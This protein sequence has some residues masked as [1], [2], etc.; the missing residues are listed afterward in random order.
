MDEKKNSIRLITVGWMI[1]AFVI[2][3]VI[4]SANTSEQKGTEQESGSQVIS[5]SERLTEETISKEEEHQLV[6]EAIDRAVADWYC[7]TITYDE[8]SAILAEIQSTG[9]S[10]GLPFL[11]YTV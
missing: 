2:I 1:A 4:V 6:R 9:D 3:S 7:G 10:E 5:G 8:A 11:M